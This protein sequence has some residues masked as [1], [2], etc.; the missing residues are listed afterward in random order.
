MNKLYAEMPTLRK[1]YKY[2]VYEHK[3]ITKDSLVFPR[4]L[5][6]IKNHFG[7]V[8]SFTKLHKYILND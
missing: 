6:V 4:S 1:R 7:I 2:C 5:I 3:L 8:V